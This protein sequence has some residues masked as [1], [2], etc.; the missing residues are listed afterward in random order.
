MPIDP[1]HIVPVLEP[2]DEEARHAMEQ[3]QAYV[4]EA[5]VNRCPPDARW[6]DQHLVMI[7]A[8]IHLVGG[9]T[10]QGQRMQ[11]QIE[12]LRQHIHPHPGAAPS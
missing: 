3:V 8:L 11:I 4:T 9:L 6:P 2:H 1:N 12:E 7:E 5:V 10:A